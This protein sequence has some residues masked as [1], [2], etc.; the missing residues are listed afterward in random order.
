[1]PKEAHTAA[2]IIS[3]LRAA[4]VLISQGQTIP[5]AEAIG[6]MEQTTFFSDSSTGMRRV[7]S[8]LS[9]PVDPE[10]PAQL[11]LWA[12]GAVHTIRTR[13]NGG[14]VT[15]ADGSSVWTRAAARVTSL[16]SAANTSTRAGCGF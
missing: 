6:T 11:P 12:Y 1:M 7:G 4:E 16:K 13:L 10:P 3:R 8:P 5:A 2:Q 9:S 15:G 14:M